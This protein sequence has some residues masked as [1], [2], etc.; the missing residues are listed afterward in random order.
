MP[1]I[2]YPYGTEHAGAAAAAT[3]ELACECAYLTYYTH[4]GSAPTRA[5]S[6]NDDRT[7]ARECTAALNGSPQKAASGRA[8]LKRG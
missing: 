2:V 5:Y 6:C 8:Y 1:A 7:G 4:R 3:D